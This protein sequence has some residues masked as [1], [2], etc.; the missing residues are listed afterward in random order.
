M[1]FALNNILDNTENESRFVSLKRKCFSIFHD[2]YELDIIKPL[3]IQF[4]KFVSN[5]TT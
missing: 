4:T 3:Q 5:N 1:Q 2:E